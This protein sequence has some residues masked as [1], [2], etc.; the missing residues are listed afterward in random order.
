MDLKY[1]VEGCDVKWC[2]EQVADSGDNVTNYCILL[3]GGEFVAKMKRAWFQA[4]A[5]K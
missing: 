3:E 2:C 5:A 4:S 1:N